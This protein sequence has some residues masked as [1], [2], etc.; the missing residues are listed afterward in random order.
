[1]QRHLDVYTRVLGTRLYPGSLNVVL[2]DPWTLPADCVRLDPVELGV[3]VN[4]VPCRIF[5]QPAFL[6]RTD[7]HESWVEQ[8]RVVEV[9]AE[10]RL[11]DAYRLAD[12][13]RV[14][15]EVPS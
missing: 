13:D 12:G 1:M 11:R 2:D 5:D 7:F 14:A 6:F 9:L 10:V 15:I 4:F 3:G 8:H